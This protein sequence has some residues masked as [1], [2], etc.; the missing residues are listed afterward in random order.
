[1]KKWQ[2][3]LTNTMKVLSGGRLTVHAFTLPGG[4]AWSLSVVC[5]DS[6]PLTDTFATISRDRE[7][8]QANGCPDSG[9]T[10]NKSLAKLH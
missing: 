9:V 6:M 10:V 2:G 8:G 3:D 4:L 1:M 7:V 5:E